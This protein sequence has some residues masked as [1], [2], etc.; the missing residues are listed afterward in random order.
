MVEWRK[1]TKLKLIEYKGGRC[2]KCEYNKCSN[3][4]E[5]HHENPNEKDF[6]VSGKSWSF[7]RLKKEFTVGRKRVIGSNPT[8]SS[9][10][11]VYQWL[12]GDP[13]KIEVV[14]SIPATPTKLLL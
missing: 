13:D 11:S 9:Y 1:R 2:E 3:A 7:D 8:L 4:L 10:W 14:G 6:T 12:D 5:F